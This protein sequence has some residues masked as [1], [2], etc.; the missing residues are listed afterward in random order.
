MRGRGGPP[1]RMKDRLRGR[2]RPRKLPPKANPFLRASSAAPKKGATRD[3]MIAWRVWTIDNQMALKPTED[4]TVV[5]PVKLEDPQ[6]QERLDGF[7]AVAEA[8]MGGIRRPRYVVQ[9]Y[10]AAHDLARAIRV[11]ARK[12][13]RTRWLA[14]LADDCVPSPTYVSEMAKA[15]RRVSGGVMTP[16]G[17]GFAYAIDGPLPMGRHYDRRQ[18]AAITPSLTGGLEGTPFWSGCDLGQW[19]DR[20]VYLALGGHSSAYAGGWR[21]DTDLNWRARE[22]GFEVWPAG[23]A[24][25]DHP[26]RPRHG[27]SLE[28]V[29]AERKLAAAHPR[30]YRAHVSPDVERAIQ[31]E[32]VAQE[33]PDRGESWDDELEADAAWI[34]CGGDPAAPRYDPRVGAMIPITPPKALADLVI[35]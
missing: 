17:G 18:V 3:G 9:V 21:C 31:A 30:L 22:A 28:V 24:V 20:E 14:L 33:R 4:V 13:P 34:A 2:P 5:L 6:P 12:A 16:R 32:L 27:L 29:P 25:V 10:D 7:R 35:V 11:G 23:R 8:L 19:W 1:A 15:A 26:E